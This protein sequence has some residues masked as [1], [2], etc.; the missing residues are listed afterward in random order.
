MVVP[1]S[2]HEWKV[3]LLHSKALCT[4]SN[5][6]QFHGFADCSQTGERHVPVLLCFASSTVYV[7]RRCMLAHYMVDQEQ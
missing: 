4:Q 3:H 2:T 7:T 6:E 5:E 1:S